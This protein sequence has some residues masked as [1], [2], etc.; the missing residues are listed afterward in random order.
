MPIPGDI[1]ASLPHSSMATSTDLL[2]ART[3]FC[4][5]MTRYDKARYD[6]Q[7]TLAALDRFMGKPEIDI[8][9]VE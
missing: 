2:D 6:L 8:T 4:E 1:S 5:T 7:I 9:E 3:Q